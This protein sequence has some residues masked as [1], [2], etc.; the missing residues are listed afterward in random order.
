MSTPSKSTASIPV[1]KSRRG[2]KG[3]FKDVQREIKKI[4]WPTPKETNRLTGIVL[5]ICGMIVLALFV[6][7]QVADT[8]V[9]ILT[10]RK[11]G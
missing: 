7:S 3:F 11:G 1:P 6:L 8:M 4:S 10:T 2:P 5:G 9:H